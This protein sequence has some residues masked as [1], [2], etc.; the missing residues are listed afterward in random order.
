MLT[1]YT[2]FLIALLMQSAFAQADEAD[3][4]KQSGE[5]PIDM[6]ALAQQMSPG[7]QLYMFKGCH[8][9][10][11]LQGEGVVPKHG[12]RLAGLPEE[13]IVRQL[14]HFKNGIRGGSFEDLYGSQMQLAV[15]SVSTEEMQLISQHIARFK[16]G[17]PLETRLEGDRQRGAEIYEQQCASCHGEEGVGIAELQGTPMA[18][19][20][21]VYLA[22]QIRN[23]SSGVR[24]AHEADLYGRQMAASVGLFE[25]EQ[26][27][28]D[29]SLYL[30]T[31]GEVEFT[32]EEGPTGVVVSFYRR[33]DVQ[34]KSAIY[35]LLDPDVTFHFPGRTTQGPQ[36]YWTYVS[37][38]GLLIPDY[39]HGLKGV[40]LIDAENGIV[41]VNEISI[42]G[43]LADGT[44]ISLPGEAEYR[45][46]GGKIVEAWVR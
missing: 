34:D 28:A 41:R 1:R 6:A 17:T 43:T 14:E 38:V 5:Q 26:D 24:G 11:G 3:P 7:A 33:L 30:A 46:E 20:L 42:S 2:V 45:V 44:P 40:E 37:Q 35:E 23:Y 19:Q 36:G 10:H 21:D 27:I 25:S 29:V 8:A 16:S 13:Y 12:P 18:G 31:L 22:D 32:L 4:G 9:C 39:V 15:N